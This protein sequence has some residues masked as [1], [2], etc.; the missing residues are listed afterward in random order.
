MTQEQK[1][2]FDLYDELFASRGWKQFCTD[3]EDSGEDF[4]RIEGIKDAKELHTLQGKLQ[5]I[6]VILNMEN[7]MEMAKAAAEEEDDA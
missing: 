6:E 7:M 2:V 4:N 1:A 5:M 3:L